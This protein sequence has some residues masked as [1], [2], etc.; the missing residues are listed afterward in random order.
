M[1]KHGLGA[2]L[3]DEKIDEYAGK[4]ETSAGGIS[5]V[6][7]NVKQMKPSPEKVDEL[8]AKLMK[9]HCK[10]MGGEEG[11]RFLEIEDWQRGLVSQGGVPARLAPPDCR[12]DRPVAS[13]K[14]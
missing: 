6:L 12:S 10:L 5:T 4:Y 9:P 14:R 11:N 7:A 2:L 13:R 8:V 1:K 3:P